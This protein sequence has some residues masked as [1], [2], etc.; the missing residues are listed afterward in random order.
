LIGCERPDAL[1]KAPNKVFRLP[2]RG[3]S[4][5][6]LHETEHVL[7]AMIDLAHQKENLVLVSFPIGHIVRHGNKQ[8]SSIR[9]G[10]QGRANKT[11]NAFAAVFGADRHF[12]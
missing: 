10:S 3:L 7:G 4:G 9:L 1:I 6:R 2:C 5:D 11:P 8:A 12:R